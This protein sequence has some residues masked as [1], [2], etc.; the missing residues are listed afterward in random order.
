MRR[1]V[2]AMLMPS[3]PQP[4]QPTAIPD[5]LQQLRPA[6]HPGVA[7]LH[8]DPMHQAAVARRRALMEAPIPA[9]HPGLEALGNPIVPGIGIENLHPATP[10]F[11][12]LRPGPGLEAIHRGLGLVP[13]SSRPFAEGWRVA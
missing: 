13:S 11:G 5:W 3:Q 4:F 6:P 8:Q 7:F 2:A 9:L 10:R 1:R 12:H